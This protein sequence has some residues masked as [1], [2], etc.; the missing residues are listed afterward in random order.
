MMQKRTG[1]GAPHR[2]ATWSAVFPSP[3]QLFTSAAVQVNVSDGLPCIKTA[4]MRW[5]M[6]Q[7]VW[8]QQ[9]LT[10]PWFSSV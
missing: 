3:S 8:L 9:N 1:P 6:H 5:C 7:D 2:A 4:V 10:S